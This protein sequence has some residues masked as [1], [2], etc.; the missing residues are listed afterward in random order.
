MAIQ[1]VMDHTGDTRYAFDPR[2]P[3]APLEAEWRFNE[4]TGTGFTAATKDRA[5]EPILTRQFDPRAEET[6]FFPRLVGG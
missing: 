2:N 5:G 4:L 3:E 6:A 1:I